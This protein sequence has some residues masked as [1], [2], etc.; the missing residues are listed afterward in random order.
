MIGGYLSF[1]GY[2]GSAHYRFTP[3]EDILPVELYDCDDRVERPSGFSP[4]V[5]KEHEITKGLPKNWPMLL[6]Y[7]KVKPLGEV[8]V[9]AGERDPLLVIGEYGK[10]RT[11]AYTSDCSP[12]W[13]SPEFVKWGHYGD[14]W[15]NIVKWLA[16]S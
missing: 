5:V 7:N 16:K 15:F 2:G 6:G 13:G 12:H 9:R 1:Q 10:G 11:A 14:V 8:Q 4:E 3:I